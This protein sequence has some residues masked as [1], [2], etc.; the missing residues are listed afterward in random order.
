[1]VLPKVIASSHSLIPLPGYEGFTEVGLLGELHFAALISLSGPLAA[2]LFVSQISLALASL[3]LSLGTQI[4]LR[5]RGKWIVICIL[6]T[7]TAFTLVIGDG[8]VDLFGAALGVAA[9]YWALR[10][11]GNESKVALRLAGLLTGLA[12]VAKLT[13][14]AALL[15]GIVILSILRVFCSVQQSSA[16][17][18]LP[19]MGPIMG[20]LLLWISIAFIPQIIKNSLLFG[21]P[22]APFIGTH[23]P[24]LLSHTWF[25]TKIVRHIVLTYPLA[26][27]FGA[28]PMQYGNIS[29]LALAFVSFLGFV[30]PARPLLKNKTLQLAVCASAALLT[31]VVLEPSIFAPR[32]FLS[33]LLVFIPGIALAAERLSRSATRRELEVGISVC[34]II[35]L[36]LSLKHFFLIYPNFDPYVFGKMTERSYVGELYQTSNIIN[37]AAKPGDRVLQLTYSTYWLRDDLL[38]SMASTEERE[39]LV[40]SPGKAEYAEIAKPVDRWEYFDGHSFRYILVDRSTFGA[41]SSELLDHLQELPRGSRLAT[42]FEGKTYSVYRLIGPDTEKKARRMQEVGGEHSYG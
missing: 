6:F 19:S 38:R 15:P 9:F 32:Y 7:S 3:L 31:W 42:L 26:L 4:G 20:K 5:R 14:L 23:I 2:R 17:R 10:T 36:L 39:R 24:V 30:K 29:P 21:A 18:L 34:V 8:K 25:S 12:I 11:D 1:M 16:K 40:G 41:Q 35:V 37:S 33:P 27:T 22:L 28:Y 13:Y